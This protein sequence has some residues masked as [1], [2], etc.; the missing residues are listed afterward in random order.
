VIPVS[1]NEKEFQEMIEPAC[2]LMRELFYVRKGRL[3]GL[4]SQ[5]RVDMLNELDEAYPL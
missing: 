3:N 5:W 4:L 2:D 1:I